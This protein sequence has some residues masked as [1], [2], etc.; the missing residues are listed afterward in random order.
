VILRNI[1]YS[2]F[3]FF[4]LPE[5]NIL[6]VGLLLLPLIVFISIEQGV[7]PATLSEFFATR[8]RYSGVSIAYN[9]SY[10]YLGGTAPMYITWLIE[11]T[12]DT[13]IPA[14]CIII[15]SILTG[16]ALTK[17]SGKLNYATD[18]SAIPIDENT[19]AQR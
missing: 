5:N 18:I 11:K 17:L 19:Q 16:L 2:L 7:M 15:S 3:A 4:Y 1:I 6:L 9:V 8:I 13:L 12:Q 14:I 10:A